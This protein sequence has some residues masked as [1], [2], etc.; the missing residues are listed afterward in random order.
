MNHSPT[1]DTGS[2]PV[3][4]PVTCQMQAMDDTERGRN[5]E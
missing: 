5:G 4:A 3:G 2:I 1:G